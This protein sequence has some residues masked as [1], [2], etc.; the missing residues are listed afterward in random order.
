MMRLYRALLHVYP[1]SFRA[2]YGEE[3]V[4][5]FAQRVRDASGWMVA[6]LWIG[7]LFEVLYNA[8]GVHL[9][10]LQQDLRYIGRMLRRSPGFALTV[11]MVTALGIGATTAAFTMVDHVLIRPLP[12]A[13]Q[14]RLVNLY[15][16]H[17]FASGKM[18]EEWD[19]S[20]ADYRDWKRMSTSFESMAAYHF[21]AM[22][23]VGQGD[24]LHLDC[25]S[26]SAEMFPMLGVKPVLG[27]VFAASD[28]RD[29][30]DGTVIF[31]YGLWQR[32]FGGDPAV[33]GRKVI[34]DDHPYTVIGVMPKDFYFPGRNVQFWTATRFG[35][36]AYEDR[37]NNYIYAVAQLKPGVSIERSRAELRLITGQLE[38]SYPKELAH[39][40]ATVTFMRDDISSQA[41]LTLKMLLAA[42]LCVLLVACMN[43]ASL[44]L[45]RA[46]TRKK[47]LAVRAAMGAG[48]E[49]LIRQMLTE[50]VL[51][52]LLGGVAGVL[53]AK[54]AL[55]LL[56]RLIPVYL[57]IAEIPPID[58]RV[59]LFALLVTLATGIGFGVVPALRVCGKQM[60]GKQDTS[61]LRETSRAG[62][63]RRERLRSTLVIAEVAGSLVLLVSCGLLIRAMWRVEAIDPGFRADNVLTMRTA[64]PMPKYEAPAL[65]QQFYQRVLTQA[66]QLPG[67]TGAAYI[68]FLP[69]IH[70]GG[71]WAVEVE[72]QPQD[73]SSRQTA[74]AR[75]VTPGFFSV[76]GI[77]LLKGRDVSESDGRDNRL[78]ALVSE[79][80]VRRYWPGQDPIGRRFH[81]GN[82]DR[83]II[84]VVGDI[85]VR[86]LERTSE[87]QV[88]MPYMQL[89]MAPYY[90]PKDLAVHVSGNAA[91][92]AQ[93]LRRIIHEADS[94]EPISDVRL[95]SDIV[96]GETGTR[97]VQV[98]VLGSFALIAFLLAAIGIHGL[99][100]SVVSSRRQEIGVRM[101]LGATPGNILGMIVRDGA[102]LAAVGIVLGIALAYI[103]GRELQALLAGVLPGDLAS[104]VTATA[105]CLVM[106]LTGSLVP[107]LRA[108][109]IDPTTAI[110]ID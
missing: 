69:I 104:F 57:P 85:R 110:R 82:V 106:T 59:L 51:L 44:L 75:H 105:L 62:G 25:A 95:L 8:I 91:N 58:L 79:S 81:F 21:D 92:L 107:A 61:D 43:L 20:P 36:S 16:D 47:E 27:R 102:V 2:E 50:S 30:A 101:A 32:E 31:G 22:N 108:V 90:A 89:T 64:L 53:I 63:G 41:K 17:S 52:S 65:R 42:A 88:Y 24:P 1:A 33:L 71:V 55:P 18:G 56:V 109:R 80:F 48:R 84:G 15:E 96:D 98:G 11:T 4:R 12:F 3:M 14:D 70:G 66:K 23:L 38:R 28:D 54:S 6:L 13:A 94:Q 40:G 103:A 78:V 45:T 10:I 37:D 100:S 9:D 76:L 93:P 19:L 74:S 49:R 46:M 68:S 60:C 29:S 87:P 39:I 72:G 34:L 86:G 83:V 97:R 7:T 77:P 67:V 99:L 35:P 5:I 26:V 73:L